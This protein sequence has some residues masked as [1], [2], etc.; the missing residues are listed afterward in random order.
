M[1]I[2]LHFGQV[3]TNRL[4][5]TASTRKLAN[6]NET[7]P[8]LSSTPCWIGAFL[9]I[10]PGHSWKKISIDIS[11]LHKYL[12]VCI[13]SHTQDMK[14]H[15]SLLKKIILNINFSFFP[16]SN[17]ADFAFSIIEASVNPSEV[18]NL[19]LLFHVK[20]QVTVSSKI[21]NTTML[22]TPSYPVQEDTDPWPTAHTDHSQ[23]SPSTV[24]NTILHY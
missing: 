19:S 4:A 15:L 24:S 18:P 10:L 12:S 2:C 7:A 13:D 11:W 1:C 20:P 14:F 9:I 17:N 5:Q 16:C 23:F 3:P 8:K 22:L 21:N 6:V